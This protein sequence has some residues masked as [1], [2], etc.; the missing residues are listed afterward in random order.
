MSQPDA[1]AEAIMWMTRRTE[2]DM[3]MNPHLE[4]LEG[5]LFIKIQERQ[6]NST[7]GDAEMSSYKKHLA[8]ELLQAVSKVTKMFGIDQ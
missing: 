5:R 3:L 4:E 1:I 2:E 7:Q 8:M 6:L